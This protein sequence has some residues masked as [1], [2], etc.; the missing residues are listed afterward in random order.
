[1]ALRL[2]DLSSA[3]EAEIR[4]AVRAGG[5]A[6]RDA[7][8]RVVRA[9]REPLLALCLHVAGRRADAEDALQ[10]ALVAVVAG[11]PGFRGEARLGTWAYRIAV[12]A[13]LRARAR[14]RDGEALD[15]DTPGG[16]GEGEMASRD[17]ARRV[18]AAMARLPAAQ[19]TVLSLFAVEGL[20]HREI[21]DI[22]GVPEG[23]VWSRLHAARRMLL[24]ALGD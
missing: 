8:E 9:L 3:E 24:H 13:A 22:L 2:P 23:T 20:S 1:M 11:L 4:A 17:S 10:E 16:G 7:E 6:R 18:A 15:P 12:R 19:R 5:G 21:A 14:R